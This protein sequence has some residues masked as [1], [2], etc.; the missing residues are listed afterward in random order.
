M[1]CVAAGRLRSDPLKDFAIVICFA[2]A[3]Q[4]RIDCMITL[5]RDR[6]VISLSSGILH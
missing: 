1:I 4:E 6:V 5:V 3:G 2:N